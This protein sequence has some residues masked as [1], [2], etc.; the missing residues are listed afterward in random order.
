MRAEL[1]L[2]TAYGGNWF[3][4]G[5]RVEVHSSLV[6][7]AVPLRPP[8]RLDHIATFE[9]LAAIIGHVL[10]VV[11]AHDRAVRLLP[12]RHALAGQLRTLFLMVSYTLTDL[13]LLF[14]S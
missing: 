12:S 10:R 6:A 11:A 2:A 9:Q 4:H 1:R 14:S 13:W 3:E 8:Y 5:N 7:P